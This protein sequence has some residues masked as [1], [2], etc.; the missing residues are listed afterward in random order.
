MSAKS[1]NGKPQASVRSFAYVCGSSLNENADVEDSNDGPQARRYDMIESFRLVTIVNA[2]FI[3]GKRSRKS[4]VI[5]P[6]NNL[7]AERF[8]VY[9]ATA[10]RRIAVVAL[11]KRGESRQTA[12]N[13]TFFLFRGLTQ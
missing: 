4:S 6:L 3:I 9:I 10:N 11:Q 8:G 12:I 1:F 13:K 7:T 5:E 2:R